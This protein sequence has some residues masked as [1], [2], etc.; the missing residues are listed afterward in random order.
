MGPEW[1]VVLVVVLVIFGGSQVPKLA[2]SLGQA[3]SEFR[4][5]LSEGGKKTDE[6]DDKKTS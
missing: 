4:K 5:G 1:I 3:Q 2:R 6:A